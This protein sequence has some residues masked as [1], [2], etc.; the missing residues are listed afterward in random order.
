MKETPLILST[1][2][3]QATIDH[4]K[5]VTR[6]TQGLN[7]I[8]KNPDDWELIGTDGLIWRFQNRLNGKSVYIK[9]P[10]GEVGDRLW[11]RET[12]YDDCGLRAHE[13]LKCDDYLYYRAD[14]EAHE[15]F[16]CLE[17]GFKW[18]SS[19][20]MPKWAARIW[21]EI[22]GLR[23]ERLQEISEW[24][25][26]AEGIYHDPIIND[27]LQPV[28]DFQYLWDTLNAKRGYPWAANNWVWRI[29][30]KEA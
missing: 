5:K 19:R 30:W 25:A 12:F 26:Q 21:L 8:N 13:G 2:M 6:R 18:R 27:Y 23:V 24:D 7:E 15:Q 14:G 17:E 9:C 16:E 10:Y 11:V 28:R 4:R 3:V 1:P 29:E 22:T 20:F